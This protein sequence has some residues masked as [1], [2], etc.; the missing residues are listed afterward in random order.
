MQIGVPKEI[1]NHEY[2]VGMT[3]AGVSMCVAAGHEV[4]IES[5]AGCGV[6]FDDEAYQQV[7]AHIEPSAEKIYRHS[8]LIVKVKE[9]LGSECEWLHQN[10]ILFGYLHL[11]AE[12]KLAKS[13][14]DKKVTA[15]AYETVTDKHGRLPLLQPMSEVAGRLSIQA[16]A[17]ALIK[18][19][20]GKGV[21]MGGVPGVAPA[22]VVVLGGGVVGS[23]AITM[24]MGLG[25]K[26]TVFDTSV[27]RLRELAVQFGPALQTRVASKQALRE[28]LPDVDVVVGAV[29]IPGASAPKLL[30]YDDLERMQP[31]TV[32]VDVAIDQGGCFESSHA[33]THEHPTYIRQ[34]IVHYCV[35][36]MPGAVPQTSTIALTNVTLPYVLRIA[37]EG[38]DAV[39]QD[40]LFSTGLNVHDGRVV[41]AA[42]EK[43]LNSKNVAKPA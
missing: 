4:W 8:D 18:P 13:L 27:E 16:A 34:G 5:D 17:M 3:P 35:A 7:G 20:G 12:P 43:A 25:A 41:N 15:I 26:V 10:Q 11:A 1:K 42:V 2:R 30:S 36:N 37:N 29:L 23:N 6:G 22:N 33:T 38:L 40:P 32:L 24:A 28:L 9:P 39:T 19:V 14:I 31:G 21:L